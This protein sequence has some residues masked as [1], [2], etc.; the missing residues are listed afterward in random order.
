MRAAPRSLPADVLLPA[1]RG[2][3][4]Q[5]LLA[6]QDRRLPPPVHRPGGGRGRRHLGRAR[7]R[8]RR[9]HLPR[10]RALLARQGRRRAARHGRA[11]RQ[12][13]GL[14]GG[15]WAARCTSSTRASASWAATASSA[16]TCRSRRASR[17]RQV[18]RRARRHALL[19]RRRLGQHGRVPR[20]AGAGRRCGSC[21]WSSSARTTST[22]WARRSTARSR[23]TDVSMRARGYGIE[24]AIASTATT[25]SRCAS[26]SRQAVE[27]AR[28]EPAAD[29]DRGRS[30]YRFRG[31]S[32]S[33]P[34]HYRTKEEVEEWKKRDPIRDPRRAHAEPRHRRRGASSRQLD[35]EVEGA[36]CEDAVRVRRGSRPQPDPEHG[37]R[38]TYVECLTDAAHPRRSAKR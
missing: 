18:P 14:L 6:G 2:G 10:A 29:A 19:L 12:G 3:G 28:K 20:G 8:L 24:P 26:A 32:M 15:R 33:D 34:G 9:R 21:R 25:C 13:D 7:R 36:R 31:H 23:S 27:R 22:R 1:L 5:G 4:G 11:V 38:V 16:G 35:D 17:S 37:R 30:T